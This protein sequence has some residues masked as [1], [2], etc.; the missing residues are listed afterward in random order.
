MMHLFHGN[1]DKLFVFTNIAVDVWEH[2][3]HG[4]EEVSGTVLACNN[5]N[6][7]LHKLSRRSMFF[8]LYDSMG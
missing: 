8:E 1:S 3:G 7:T 6:Q 4:I 2:A 5:E